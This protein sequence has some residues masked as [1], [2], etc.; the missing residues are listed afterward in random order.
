MT[1]WKYL[2]PKLAGSTWDAR[3]PL[4]WTDVDEPR[5]GIYCAHEPSPWLLG[6][7]TI[8]SEVVEQRGETYWG[9]QRDFVTGDGYVIKLGRK[10]ARAAT[11]SLVGDEVHDADALNAAF[12]RSLDQRGP[13]A[14]ETVEAMSKIEAAK[15][16]L[17]LRIPL[18]CG[19]CRFSRVFRSDRC[20]IVV[21]AFWR[22]GVREVQ[23]KT[24]AAAIDR[25]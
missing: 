2:V 25:R 4:Y 16:G 18:E 8:S 14:P 15:Q 3:G 7:F 1:G 20:Q 6:S 13:L 22:A 21:S 10:S 9:W 12:R 5:V 23:L 19:L 24:F 11:Q 17:R